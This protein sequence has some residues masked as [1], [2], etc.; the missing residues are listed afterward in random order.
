MSR[1]SFLVTYFSTYR[2]VSVVYLPARET[3]PAAS[4]WIFGSVLVWP[5]LRIN[6][7]AAGCSKERRFSLVSGYFEGFLMGSRNEGY[8]GQLNRRPHD[9]STRLLFQCNRD[10]DLTPSRCVP[11]VKMLLEHL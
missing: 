7:T 2:P 9:A 4:D 8:E 5:F 3:G 1:V 6:T 11:T 10:D